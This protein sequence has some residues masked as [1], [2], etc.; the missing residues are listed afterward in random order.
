MLVRLLVEVDAFEAEATDYPPTAEVI[1]RA[2]A[3][4]FRHPLMSD[5]RRFHYRTPEGDIIAG[6]MLVESVTVGE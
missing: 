5:P 1:A 6:V 3:E 2:T 4:H